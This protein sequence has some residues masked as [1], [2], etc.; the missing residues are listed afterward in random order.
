MCIWDGMLA[1]HANIH[2]YNDL[3]ATAH[4]ICLVPHFHREV[5]KVATGARIPKALRL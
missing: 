3:D 1:V 2:F 5:S 4:V